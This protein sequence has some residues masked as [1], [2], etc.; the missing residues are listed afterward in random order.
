MANPPSKQQIIVLVEW[1]DAYTNT[2]ILDPRDASGIQSYAPMIVVGFL[3]ESR[4][5]AVIIGWQFDPQDKIY[6]Q[7]M[8]I[9]RPLVRNIKTISSR[10]F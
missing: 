2:D 6:R 5:D 3:I 1:D 9:P 8:V 7:F 4:D 10:R